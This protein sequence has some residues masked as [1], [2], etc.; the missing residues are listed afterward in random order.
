MLCSRYP[1]QLN[2]AK[3]SLL[4]YGKITRLLTGNIGNKFVNDFKLVVIALIEQSYNGVT[5][6]LCVS[7][8]KIQRYDLLDTNMVDLADLKQFPKADGLLT[9][10][11]LAPIFHI[12][13]QAFTELFPCEVFQFVDFPQSRSYFSD[14][15]ICFV[16]HCTPA[17][18][19]ACFSLFYRKLKMLYSVRKVGE[20]LTSIQVGTYNIV[21]NNLC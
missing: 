10:F 13:S 14:F 2:L 18:L 15:F 6:L 5:E 9:A 20:P 16:V 8:L 3:K 11:A 7:F 12:F 21:E 17:V 1:G 4:T 19:W